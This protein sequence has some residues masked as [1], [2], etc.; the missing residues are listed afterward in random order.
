MPSPIPDFSLPDPDSVQAAQPIPL[1]Q[2]VRPQEQLSEA[3]LVYH[4]TELCPRCGKTINA[5][6]ARKLRLHLVSVVLLWLVV[7]VAILW[8]VCLGWFLDVHD[9]WAR[10]L[11]ELPEH[12]EIR[13]FARV[14][15]IYFWPTVVLPGVAYSWPRVYVMRCRKCGWRE[16]RWTRPR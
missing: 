1:A 10:V 14:L 13:D 11:T 4:N 8:L 2:P 16:V 5:F 15:G 3:A 12:P 7:P 9:D 6:E